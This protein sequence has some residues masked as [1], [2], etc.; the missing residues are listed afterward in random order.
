MNRIDQNIYVYTFWFINKNRQ[1]DICAVFRSPKWLKTENGEWIKDFDYIQYRSP[2][3]LAQREM[4]TQVA[5]KVKDQ[6]FS[7]EEGE[8]LLS[9]LFP[10]YSTEEEETYNRLIEQILTASND[11]VIDATT[12]LDTA[13][14]FFR[15]RRLRKQR[16]QFFTLLSKHVYPLY[17][18]FSVAEYGS[19]RIQHKVNELMRAE[20]RPLIDL[21]SNY[22]LLAHLKSWRSFGRRGVGYTVANLRKRS[23]IEFQDRVGF[24][25]R[26]LWSREQIIQFI[27]DQNGREITTEFLLGFER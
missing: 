6:I 9:T 17:R 26:G 25:K 5:E 13:R 23:A 10:D 11:F 14:S 4:A 16:D 18:F 1:G 7:Q 8:W 24:F 21:G 20:D 12:Y 2:Y 15:D 22:Y 19:A 3:F 27:E